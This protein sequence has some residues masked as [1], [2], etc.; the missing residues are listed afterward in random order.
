M[1]E[2]LIIP[3]LWTDRALQNAIDIKDYLSQQFSH[4]EFEHFTSLLRAF[5]VAVSA[6]PQLYPLSAVQ[7]GIRRAVLSK[8]VSA[9]YRVHKQQIEVLAILDNRRDIVNLGE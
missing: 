7:P 4:K 2:Q 3:V 8:V 6:F 1:P 5:E 9:F